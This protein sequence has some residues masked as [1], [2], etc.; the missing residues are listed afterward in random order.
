LRIARR[1]IVREFRSTRFNVR[2]EEFALQV[3]VSNQ[4][5]QQPR[6]AAAGLG[7]EIAGSEDPRQRFTD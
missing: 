1:P 3:L 5:S 7:Y 2:R 6:I 4:I